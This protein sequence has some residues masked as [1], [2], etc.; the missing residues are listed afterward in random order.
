[1]QKLRQGIPNLLL[2]LPILSPLIN[3]LILSNLPN[4]ST[5]LSTAAQLHA[6]NRTNPT[7]QNEQNGKQQCAKKSRFGKSDNFSGAGKS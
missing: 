4:S 2:L 5:I 3:S 1:M 6:S 7:E